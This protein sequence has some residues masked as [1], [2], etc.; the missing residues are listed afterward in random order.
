MYTLFVCGGEWAKVCHNDH[1]H[2]VLTQCSSKSTFIYSDGCDGGNLESWLPKNIQQFSVQV[3]FEKVC[4][5][6]SFSAFSHMYM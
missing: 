5:N 2:F 3:I 6:Y 4:I 1:Y